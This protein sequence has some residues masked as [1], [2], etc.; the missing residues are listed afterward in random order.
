MMVKY[1]SNFSNHIAAFVEQKRLLGFTYSSNERILQRFDQ[2]CIEYFPSEN[3]LTKELCLAWAVRRDM[4]Q[5][6]SFR[7][8]LTTIRELAKYLNRIGEPAFIFPKKF[9]PLKKHRPIPY[10][11]TKAEIA[12]IWNFLDGIKPRTHLSV[13]HLVIPAIFRLLYCCGLRPGEARKLKTLDVDLSSGKIYIRESKGCKDRIVMLADDVVEYFTDYNECL[14]RLLPGREWFFPK[15]NDTPYS[16]KWL[17]GEFQKVREAFNFVQYAS[18]PPRV[19]DFRHTF[20]THCLYQWLNEGKDITAMLP[21]LSAYMG[22]AHLSDTYY[23]IQL[24]PGQFEEVSGLDFSKY[25]SLLPEV[26]NIE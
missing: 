9:A 18:G 22:H 26:N 11:Y 1:N 6:S 15:S 14:V 24:V 23:Y 21:Y 4:E 8:R 10:I 5:I 7:T 25:E 20:A 13:R 2:F 3:S 12:S 16:N 19:Y 17:I